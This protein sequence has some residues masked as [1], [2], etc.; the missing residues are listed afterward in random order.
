MNPDAHIVVPLSAAVVV[1]VAAF[2]VGFLVNLV[3]MKSIFVSSA[4][5]E[6]H[7]RQCGKQYNVSMGAFE[8]GLTEIKVGMKRLDE[9]VFKMHG[10]LSS[11]NARLRTRHGEPDAG[12]WD[13]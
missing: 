1:A 10:E 8:N 13:K 9:C 3:T 6:E 5:C 4:G 2:V 7:R 11:I 12:G